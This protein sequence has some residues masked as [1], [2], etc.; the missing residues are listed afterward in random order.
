MNL[1]KYNLFED[2]FFNTKHKYRKNFEYCLLAKRK[3]VLFQYSEFQGTLTS[4]W[5]LKFYQSWLVARSNAVLC[6]LSSTVPVDSLSKIYISPHPP[7]LLY[8][9]NQP[10]N[11]PQD[12][13]NHRLPQTQYCLIIRACKAWNS[14]FCELYENLSENNS[15][16]WKI[17]PDP[18]KL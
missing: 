7:S 1:F 10:N 13:Q 3:T 14:T 12:H 11:Q 18:I 4:C 5:D 16:I 6:K 8:L 15:K 17:G 9:L 2:V